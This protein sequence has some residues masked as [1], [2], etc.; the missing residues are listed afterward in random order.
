M[1]DDEEDA[2]ILEGNWFDSLGV[3]GIAV[4]GMF[5]AI[6]SI[7]LMVLI[8][9]IGAARLSDAAV[10]VADEAAFEAPIAA[11]ATVRPADANAAW[12]VNSEPFNA[13]P[14]QP[15]IAVI[16]LDDGI[17]SHAVQRALDW[18]SP[19]TF[20][21]A[22]DLDSSQN[23]LKTI[24][25]AGREALALLPMG[26][27]P[28]FGRDPNV[29]RRN[30]SE[31]ELQRRLGWHLARS[32]GVVGAIDQHG[33]DIMRDIVALRIVGQGLSAEGLLYV[34]ARSARNS[35]AAPRLRALGI[36]TARN[37]TRIKQDDTVEAALMALTDAEKHAFTW[38]AA[39]VVV[40]AGSGS[41]DVLADWLRNRNQGIAIA[42]ISHVM[43]RLRTGPAVAAQAE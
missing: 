41:M 29:L 10:P 32:Q 6:L 11:I 22:A 36:P 16:V 38:G 23:R 7:V 33:G 2:P 43:R 37:T 18:R 17:N 20:A 24:R 30:L 8:N 19:L 5:A 34:D 31:T 39:I 3:G 14:G 21:V 28:D 25:R 9:Q 27:G 12:I 40:E 26:Y 13:K 1:E 15:L 35:I 42:P 4:C